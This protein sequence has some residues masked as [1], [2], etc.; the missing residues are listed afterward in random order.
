MNCRCPISRP[1]LQFLVITALVAQ[2][3]ALSAAPGT[4]TP[5]V[6]SKSMGSL[7]AGRFS[8]HPLVPVGQPDARET[9]DLETA[10][11][12][13][14][15]RTSRDDVQAITTFLDLH[16]QSAWR[17]SLLADLG[18]EYYHT[19]HFSKALAAWEEVWRERN[20]RGQSA[21][22]PLPIQRAAAALANLYAR[23]GRMETL[24]HMLTEL[25]GTQLMGEFAS[26]VK[27]ASD[28]LW[29]MDHKPEIA[30]RCG[31]LA[32]DRIR[33]WG[34]RTNIC[35]PLI[36]KSKSTTNGICLLDVANL[37]RDLEMHYQ[38]AFRKPGSAIL[39]PSVVHWKVGHYAALVRE[40]NGLYQAQ[41]PTFW[42]D[43]W[44][45]RS[46]L[47]EEA[48]G[49]FLVPSGPLP[50]GW[51]PVPD[52]EARSVWGK[53]ATGSGDAD[54]TGPYDECLNQDPQQ[55][56]AMPEPNACMGMAGWDFSL[57]LVNQRIA[58]VPIGYRPPV[59]PPVFFRFTMNA[60]DNW[61][62]AFASWWGTTLGMDWSCNW[63]SFVEDDP[64][65][66]STGLRVYLEGGWLSFSEDPAQPGTFRCQFRNPGYIQRV[67]VGGQDL[68]Y[69]WRFP[70]GTS[71]SYSTYYSPSGSVNR[72][73]LMTAVTDAAGNSVLIEYDNTF[74]GRITGIVDALGKRTTLEY[75]LTDPG[76][77]PPNPI[78]Q[79]N[80][81]FNWQVTKITDPFGRSATFQ[82]NLIQ[83][84]SPPAYIYY[85]TNITDVVGMTSSMEFDPGFAI[86]AAPYVP[87]LT[88]P[89]GTTTFREFVIANRNF[90]FMI[91]DPNG[92][93]ERIQYSESSSVN[94]SGSDQLETVP[95]GMLAENDF[96]QARNVYYWSKK[97]Y[98][99]GFSSTDYTKAMIFHFTHGDNLTA[100]GPLLESVKLPLENRVWFNYPGQGAGWVPGTDDHPSKIGRVLD[101]GST[102]LW[103][104]GRNELGNVTN[105][106]DPVGR[107]FSYIYA[108]N[109]VDLLEVR[110]T[111]AGQNVLLRKA[112]YNS[113]HLP[114]SIIEPSGQTNT[115]TYNARGQLLTFTNPRHETTTFGYDT[116]GYLISIDGPL[117]G[118]QDY[119][120][121]TY[122]GMGRVHTAIDQDGYTVTVDYDNLDRLTKVT[123]PDGTYQQI[124]YDRLRPGT[125]RDRL[126][127]MTILS[128]T[129]LAQLASVQDP[130]GRLTRFQWCRCG[131]LDSMLDPLGR[132]TSW[133]RD[134][135]GRVTSKT[136]VDGSV[137]HYYFE[138]TTSRLRSILDQQNQVTEFTYYPDNMLKMR[139]Y[140]DTL[141]PMPSVRF[142]YDPDYARVATM[143]DGQGLTTYAYNPISAF[144]NL[145]AGRLAAITGPF[146][147][148]TLTLGYDELGRI[149]SRSLGGVG[150]QRV[151]DAAGRMTQLTNVLGTFTLSWE[152]GSRRLSTIQYPNGQHT[153][154]AY[155]P[156]LQDQLL[157]R[158]TNYRPD[159]SVQSEFTHTYNPSGQITNWTQL[160]AGIL[161]TW[162]PAYDGADRLV[163]MT[164]GQG[165]STVQSFTYGYDAADNRTSEQ[166]NAIQ[167]NFYYNSLN[168][169]VA[170][171]NSAVGGIGY[172]WDAENQLTA[173]TN[174]NHR[175]EFSYDGYGRR[176]RIV[177]KDNGVTTDARRYIW[178]G[179]QLCE[180]RDDTGG[181]VLKRYSSYG[182]SSEAASDLPTGHYFF[183]L[184]HLSSVREM[185][186]VSGTLRAQ[187]TYN[188]YGLRLRLGGDL[189]AGFGFAGNFMHQPSGL[190]L[191]V[192]R[193]YDVNLAR[194]LSRDPAGEGEGFNRYAYVSSDPVGLID[195]TGYG[196][197]P[198]AGKLINQTQS[199]QDVQRAIS[200]GK[201]VQK[202][203]EF[204]QSARK[205]G[206]A[207]AIDKEVESQGKKA[208]DK[209]GPKRDSEEIKPIY[210][211]A[212]KTSKQL[213][214]TP[215][216]VDTWKKSAT[217]I[218]PTVCDPPAAKLPPKP[219]PPPKPEEDSCWFFCDK[220]DPSKAQPIDRRTANKAQNMNNQNAAY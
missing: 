130:L 96:L 113:Q 118:T 29:T 181:T 94:V 111:R 6:A 31:P 147:N 92:D 151:F 80:V 69:I 176:I 178:A 161:Q 48:S 189:E 70:D 77:P 157:Q 145:G 201:D 144:P 163:G 103:Q 54:A 139:S 115:L 195:P 132:M 192:F 8:R 17:A 106:I 63:N 59:G 140:S 162:Q 99:E 170:I 4:E 47:D 150:F 190:L 199:G 133:Q 67:T 88:T 33:S 175:T 102:Q 89:Y 172:E 37:A 62:R 213:S 135:Q 83:D 72:F 91:T 7:A 220:P 154:Y 112:A 84:G 68:G 25:E 218:D 79:G 208:A 39:L 165:G 65:N 18:E 60:Q 119:N 35:H 166:V 44:A 120:S 41:D 9:K 85:L 3:G 216:P 171:S 49:Y 204:T 180:E 32:L 100:C 28:G 142:T 40:A 158:I 127:R 53:G 45:S 146:A 114:V 160:Q 207:Q 188:P 186:D 136:Y 73:A 203:V 187:Y 174:G 105:S 210:D 141:A 185:N 215:L 21:V 117:P 155:Y 173:I 196:D 82:Y 168:Q 5:D 93:S 16:P 122:D 55:E 42:N 206:V 20:S 57:M 81:Q 27:R 66:P 110:Q 75:A 24:R 194:W 126:G 78:S 51:R 169:L 129:P 19:G 61:M 131:E 87:T 124:T 101:D 109:G 134:I 184:D 148:D 104:F 121:Y 167:R 23:L 36:F 52:A 90:G 86:S 179:M 46:T 71:R 43:T 138:R 143:Q 209:V 183:A 205:N 14:G 10:L 123:Y 38:I 12:S 50:A 116:N 153:Q 95:A 76:F 58:D 13:F 22:L 26:E 152:G 1:L 217:A 193:E 2:D 11:S 200:T 164:V 56:T 202:A 97:A 149:V 64:F 177:E 214:K 74:P 219:P 191:S 211:E 159:N 34:N 30:F 198:A 108:T 156:N 128:Y 107:T 197:E 125:I 212:D 137:E 98:A 15:A 182:V